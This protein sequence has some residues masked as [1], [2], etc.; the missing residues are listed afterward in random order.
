MNAYPLAEPS[1]KEKEKKDRELT[2]LLPKKS[3]IRE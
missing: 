3:E 2:I 1:K